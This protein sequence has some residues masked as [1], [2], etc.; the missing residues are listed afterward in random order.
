[1]ET[2][3]IDLSPL[4][5]LGQ[6]R[7]SQVAKRFRSLVRAKVGEVGHGPARTFG[8]KVIAGLVSLTV[9]LGGGEE[10]HHAEGCQLNP[11]DS[12]IDSLG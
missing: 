4:Q 1:M 6:V 7:M 9:S 5:A 10:C 3:R 2:S 8:D 11:L 12:A